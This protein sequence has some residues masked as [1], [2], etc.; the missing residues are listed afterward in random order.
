MGRKALLAAASLTDSRP[1]A[2]PAEPGL[3]ERPRLRERRRVSDPDHALRVAAIEHVREITHR[4]NDLV[5]LAALREGFPFAGT[6]VSF[7]SFYNGIHRGREQRG[8]AALTITTAASKPGRPRP[9]EDD[10]DPEGDFTYAYREPRQPTPAAIRAAEADN[11]ALA[12]AFTG[13]VP[14]IWFVGQAPGIYQPVAPVFIRR[15]DALARR[16]VLEVGL[17]VADMTP[18]GVTSSEDVRRYAVGETRIRLHQ[19]RFRLD[20]LRAY[21]EQCT[22]CRLREVSLVD[23]A[24]IVPDGHVD[25]AAVVVNGLALCSIHH[26]AYDRNLLSVDP[27]GVVHITPRL[28]KARDGPMLRQGLQEFHG[29]P[30]SLPRERAQRP[31][32]ERLAWRFSAFEEQA[33]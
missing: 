8:P 26:A 12:A 9:Y 22:I 19:Q 20:V 6:R 25:G 5:P 21:G 32:P 11:R 3:D 30:I 24:H 10:V 29:Q 15:N 13:Q 23:A 33:A 18:A 4:F 27:A 14:L 2:G 17:P 28:L 16:V 7:G 1:W 31:D